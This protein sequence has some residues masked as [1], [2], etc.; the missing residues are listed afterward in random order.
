MLVHVFAIP[1]EI[2]NPSTGDLGKVLHKGSVGVTV[3]LT[4][5][6]FFTNGQFRSE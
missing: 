3:F 1:Y 6:A 2:R 5:P 4:F